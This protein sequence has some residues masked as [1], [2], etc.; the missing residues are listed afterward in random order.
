MALFGPRRIGLA[1]G[2]GAARGLAH[3]GVL[4]VLETEGLAPDVITGTSIGALVGAFYAAGVPIA[5]IESIALGFDLKVVTGVSELA[6][7]EGAV[8]SG[9]KVQA[10]L[11]EHL[12]ATFEE[13]GLPFGCVATDITRNQAVRFTTGDLIGAV[14]ASVS[15]PLA[16]VPVRIGDMLLIDGFVCDPVPVDFA[17]SLGA[18]TIVA[19]DVF[20]SGTVVMPETEPKHAAVEVIRELRATIKN[21]LIYQRGV[22]SIDILGAVSEAFEARVAEPSLRRA[23]VVISPDV[24]HLTGF[25]FGEAAAAIRAGEKAARAA[26]DSIRKRSRR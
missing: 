12:P 13:L 26:V 20:G 23:Q 15:V 17:R 1:L 2:S 6:L 24:H 11:R 18:Q 16:F 8:L 21:G 9:E 14:R 3:I 19:V 10:F 4:K 5:D 22:S 7:G 25:S